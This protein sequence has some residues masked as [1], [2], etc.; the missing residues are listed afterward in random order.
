M[1][2]FLRN[3]SRKCWKQNR[4]TLTFEPQ[5]ETH[6]FHL[7]GSFARL[8]RNVTLQQAS[9]EMNTIGAR[10]AQDYPD[11]NKDWGVV[12]ERLSDIVVGQELRSSLLVLLAAVG[13]VLLIGCANLANLTLARGVARER[14]VAIRSA[15]RAGRWRLVRQFL[16]KTTIPEAGQKQRHSVDRSDPKKNRGQLRWNRLKGGPRDARNIQ[17]HRARRHVSGKLH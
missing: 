15:L 11:S 13:M 2:T 16:T 9:A 5:N 3:G 14:E 12:V 1:Y 6:N 10:I 4:M 17:N 7:F 8:K